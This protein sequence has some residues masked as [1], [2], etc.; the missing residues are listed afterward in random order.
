MFVHIQVFWFALLNSFFT[1]VD[2]N[3]KLLSSALCVMNREILVMIITISRPSVILRLDHLAP[4]MIELVGE[5]SGFTHMTGLLQARSSQDRRQKVS[6]NNRTSF[7]SE[8]T[9]DNAV[10]TFVHR[11]YCK[12]FS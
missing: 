2:C 4:G 11:V 3:R 8:I 10:S 12:R 7:L 9:Q 5:A 1:L 6:L